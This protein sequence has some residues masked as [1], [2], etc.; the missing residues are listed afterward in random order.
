MTR[1][2]SKKELRAA[3][4]RI[5]ERYSIRADIGAALAETLIAEFQDDRIE[6]AAGALLRIR[7]LAKEWQWEHGNI[8]LRESVNE[9]RKLLNDAE[10]HVRVIEGADEIDENETLRQTARMAKAVMQG[11]EV[12]ARAPMVLHPKLNRMTC[13]LAEGYYIIAGEPNVGKS[14][15]VQN[16]MMSAIANDCTVAAYFSFDD[17]AEMTIKRLVSRETWEI[18]VNEHLPLSEAP[19]RIWETAIQATGERQRVL[20]AAWR[21]IAGLQ[22]IGRLN[23]FDRRQVR[24]ME[25][26]EYQIGQLRKRH[27]KRLIV[28][29]DAALKIDFRPDGV[30][31][32][33]EIEDQRA[34]YLDFLSIK[35]GLPLITTHELRKRQAVDRDA[36]PTMEDTKGSGRYGYNAKFGAMIYPFNREAW[37]EGKSSAAIAYVDKNKI[38]EKTGKIHLVFERA[39][40]HI[41]EATD[42]RKDRIAPQDDLSDDQ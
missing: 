32:G 31:N 38:M 2:A 41:T 36:S 14:S 10:N 23:I 24:T 16:M 42:E 37:K 5:M 6:A 12:P 7:D 27:G 19:S 17:S 4:S 40:N 34:D 29:I 15:L 33:I 21:K 35:Y 8:S 39:F 9:C 25:E 28:C 22:D 1:M 18:A 3:I 26:L 30:K 20:M 13:G 11:E